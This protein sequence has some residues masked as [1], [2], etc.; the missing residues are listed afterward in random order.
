[1]LNNGAQ[2]LRRGYSFADGI[3][4]DSGELDAGLLFIC[5]QKDPR[6]QFIPIQQRLASNDALSEF[7]LHT[8]SGVFACPPGVPVNGSIGDGL[9]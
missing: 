7:L 1:V 9:L 8:G 5:F 3:D 2:I 6:G 4:P